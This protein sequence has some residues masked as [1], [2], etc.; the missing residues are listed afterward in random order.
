MN[1][2]RHLKFN[3]NLKYNF[4]K[5]INHSAVPKILTMKH[6]GFD[7]DNRFALTEPFKMFTDE[8]VDHIRDLTNDE[9]F[10]RKCQR[11]APFASYVLRGCME[12]SSFLKDMYECKDIQR[13][14][15]D[16]MGEEV[17]WHP[18]T[19]EASHF[20]I[21]DNNSPNEP[22]FDW[23][24]DSQPFTLLADFSHYPKNKAPEGGCTL[25]KKNN[26]EEIMK[27]N[28]P[29]P[30]FASIVRAS[31]VIHKAERA[32]YRRAIYAVS[33]SQKDFLKVDNSDVLLGAQYSDKEDLFRQYLNFRLDR[34]E[35]Q[36]E[37]AVEN[38]EVLG[39]VKDTVST[40]MKVTRKFA[41]ACFK[42]PP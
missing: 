42:G 30:G 20:N 7:D 6:L 5:H 8:A 40:E 36:L 12:Q 34:I 13:F 14:F 22:I 29:E 37:L 15:S 26:S 16:I 9:D 32:N 35:K 31:A 2:S 17:M 19:W 4:K 21:Q 41:N 38:P 28:Y 24:I 39:Q 25:L 27:I 1:L 10:N 3:R 23:H 18:I 33:L 11:K